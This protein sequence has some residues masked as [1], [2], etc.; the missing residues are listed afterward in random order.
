MH[1]AHALPYRQQMRMAAQVE[2]PGMQHPLGGD[3]EDTAHHH[4][5]NE[6]AMICPRHPR[7]P[8]RPVLRPIG[9]APM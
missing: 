8:R 6:K 5:H 1:V 2:R 3:L 4:A 9:G 7:H